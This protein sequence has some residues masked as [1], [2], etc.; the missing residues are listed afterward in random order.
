[1]CSDKLTRSV[2]EGDRSETLHVHRSGFKPVAALARVRASVA[3]FRVLVNAATTEADVET[4][5][6]Q[7]KR[8]PS[9]TLR[10]SG[11]CLLLSLVCTSAV[12]QQQGRD[13]L[14]GEEFFRRGAWAQAEDKLAIVLATTAQGASSDEKVRTRRRCLVMLSESCRRLGRHSE[15]LEYALQ[16]RQD[17]QGE[18][19]AEFA[20]LL[21]Q[22]AIGIAESQ[23]ALA[24]YSEARA[25][26]EELLANRFA[27]LKDFRK[28]QVLVN[29]A[30]VEQLTDRAQPATDHWREADQL[31]RDFLKRFEKTVSPDDVV[32]VISRLVECQ[33]ALDRTAP[34]EQMLDSLKAKLARLPDGKPRQL[35]VLLELGTH[36]SLRK[37]F[38]RAEKRFRQALEVAAPDENPRGAAQIHQLLANAYREQQL[39]DKAQTEL[40]AAAECLQRVIASAKSEAMPADLKQLRNLYQ[41][42]GRVPEAISTGEQLLKAQTETLGPTHPLVMESSSVLGGLYGSLGQY[43]RA[44]PLLR[45]VVED[46]RKPEKSPTSLARALNNLG[47]VERGVGELALAS[48]SFAEAL[49]LREK[50]LASDDPELATSYNNLA[51]VCLVQG[52]FK[53]A[54]QLYQRV[55]ERCRE[56]GPRANGLQSVTLLNLAMAYKSQGQFERAGELCQESLKLLEETAGRETMAS[57]GHYNALAT[58]A[59]GQG[60]YAESYQWAMKSLAVCAT[61]QHADHLAAAAAHTQIGIVACLGRAYETAESHWQHALRIQ[62]AN[63]QVASVAFTLNMLGLLAYQQERFADAKNFFENARQLHEDAEVSPQDRYNTLCNLAAVYRKEGRTEEALAA[64]RQAIAIPEAFRSETFGEAEQGRAKFLAQFASAFD[65]QVQWLLEDKNYDAAFVAAEQSR[66]RTFLDQLNLAG[67]DLRQTLP[68]DAAKRLLPREQELR[69]QLQ[70]LRIQGKLLPEHSTQSPEWQSLTRELN[71]AQSEY[72]QVWNEIRDSSQVYS[73]LLTQERTVWT[74]D[75]LRREVIDPDTLV[76]FYHLGSQQSTVLVIGDAA[77]PVVAV[78]LEVT[79]DQATRLP[80]LPRLHG[81]AGALEQA[82]GIRVP[83]EPEG[84]SPRTTTPVRGLTPSGSPKDSQRGIGGTIETEKGEKIEADKEQTEVTTGPLT[85]RKSADLVAWYRQALRQRQ[86]DPTRGIGGV[87]ETTK[88]T[89][90]STTS[91]MAVADIL[92]PEQLR[93]AIRERRPKKLV[94]IPDGALHNLPFEALLVRGGDSPRFVL[95]EF[96]PIAYAPSANI[97]V[98]LVRRP[99]SS[100]EIRRRLLTLGNPRYRL[101]TDITKTDTKPTTDASNGVETAVAATDRSGDLTR[102]MMYGLRGSLPPLP[103][104][105]RECERLAECFLRHGITVTK[106]LDANATEQ[107]FVDSAR[108]RGIVHLAAHGLVDE[109]YGNLFGAIALT[110]PNDSTLGERNDGFLSYNEILQ[111]PLSDCELAVLS[112]CQTNVGPDRPLEAGSTLA[113]AFLAAGA[114]RVIASHWSVSDESTAELVAGFFERT[115]DDL[116]KN[117]RLDVAESLHES[118]LKIR[119]DPRWQSPYYWAPFVLL[120][121]SN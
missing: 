69:L 13:L 108:G 27:K 98:N 79:S 18:R 6:S 91:F 104:T 94:I 28:L 67:V 37:D 66:N 55:L 110:P 30:T 71:Q 75:K 35:R 25:T 111:L 59:R 38:P 118:K 53:R 49:Q 80:E 19:N 21:Q 114:R 103:G 73:K 36:A 3:K 89:T 65:M 92:F 31:G 54:I 23:M 101:P 105:A 84:V 76:L 29:L 72:A 11:V 109:R 43:G 24:D 62:R 112:A 10:V 96:P 115:A 32:A 88:G 93:R 8:S 9:L 83:G 97:L 121:P 58:M 74:L 113:Q 106:L 52:Q 99:A 15:A 63:Q 107:Q 51:S 50:H 4:V 120:G 95:D 60:R 42:L 87:V 26:L 57:V 16:Y 1:M 78:S 45:A 64:L 7:Q 119:N 90:V 2:S 68:D 47:A 39:R 100:P 61:H 14:A 34:A 20:E 41:Q 70:R 82:A 5:A 77:K 102:D 85:R 48:E 117:N 17:L 40:A 46:Y 56:R 12:A 33:E 44:R 81:A 116:E 22:N 86:F